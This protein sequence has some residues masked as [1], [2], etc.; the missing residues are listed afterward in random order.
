MDD[1]GPDLMPV[2]HPGSES[3]EVF[4]Q[5]GLQL[6]WV[7]ANDGPHRVDEAVARRM[8]RT[9]GVPPPDLDERAPVV[10]RPGR[11]TGLT[12]EVRLEHGGTSRLDDV[13]PADLPL[14]YHVL[15]DDAGN[16]RRLVVSPGRCWLPDEPQWGWA[17]QLYAALSTTSAGIGD[18]TDLR[19]L[20]EWTEEL[21]GG[22]LLVNPLHAVAPV[23]P[24]ESSPYLPATRRFRNPV[25]LRV[26]TGRADP[27]SPGRVDRDAAWTLKLA[28]LRESYAERDD[29]EGFDAWRAAQGQ[30]LEDFA[31]W[32]VLATEHGGDWR[33]WPAELR[34]PTGDAVRDVARDLGDEVEFHAWLQWLLDRQL[35]E[36]TGGLTVIQDLPIGVSGGGADA[37]SWQGV[38]AEG[39][40]VGAPPDALNTVGQDW[41][42]PPFVP[43]RLRMA[44]YEPFI[45]SVRATMAGTGGLRIDHV[46]GL[47][48]LWWIPQGSGPIDGCYVRY[49]AEDLLDIVCLESH[50]ARA[51]VVGEDLGTVE[52]GVTEAL[53]ERGI[54]GYRVLWFEDDEPTDW[55]VL[56][57]ASVTTHDL[58][59]VTGLWTGVDVEDQLASSGMDPDDVRAGREELLERLRRG[60]LPASA[61]PEEAVAHAY[62]RLEEAPSMLLALSLEDALGAPRRP[63]L[64]GTTAR[65]NWCIP[66]PVPVDELVRQHGPPPVL[67]ALRRTAEKRQVDAPGAEWA[68][69]P[70]DA[71]LAAEGQGLMTDEHRDER[72]GWRNGFRST[73]DTGL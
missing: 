21:G 43:W 24:L 10:T 4:R 34:D 71:G 45:Q 36:A 54:L 23:V 61:G 48:R 12:G 17:V 60:G 52:D 32:S 28:T 37:W 11:S 56:S 18:L 58:P 49:P 26:G 3:D 72:R 5:A 1:T 47:F 63:N 15:L 51:V 66:L 44:D 40:T 39:T 27:V 6:D 2:P 8:L 50:R 67:A 42:S 70:R 73:A 53:Q 22:F 25:Y 30:P 68:P 46:M 31:V 19:A 7:D 9:I 29:R 20:R 41:G 13:V 65:D 62:A 59:T 33:A 69:P 55:P 35:A 57:L 38:L 16:E 64:P 14:G